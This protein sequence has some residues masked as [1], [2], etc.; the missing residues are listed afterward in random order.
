VTVSEG[1]K[2]GSGCLPVGRLKKGHD[3][4]HTSAEVVF[5]VATAFP[6]SVGVSTLACTLESR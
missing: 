3:S 4:V 1:F 2:D 6:A 5:A